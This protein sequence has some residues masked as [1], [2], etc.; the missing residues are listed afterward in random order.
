MMDSAV[1][2]LEFSF[3]NNIINS[4]AYRRA[5]SIPKTSE[6]KERPSE[7]EDAAHNSVEFEQPIFKSL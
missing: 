7:S 3:E 4:K 1:A 6:T 5:L 2:S